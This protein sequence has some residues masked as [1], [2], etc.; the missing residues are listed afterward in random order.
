[1]PAHTL[2]QLTPRVWWLNPLS[3]T[4]RPTLGVVAGQRGS[5]IIDAG[6]SPAHIAALRAELERH[7]LP[8]PRLVALTHW[9]WDHIFGAAALDVPAIAGRETQRVVRALAGLPWDDEALDRRV[10]AGTEIAFCRDMIKAELP[11]RSRLEIRPPEVAFDG[12]L[13]VDLGGAACRLIHVGGDHSPD[14]IVVHLPAERVVF[15]GDATYDDLYHGPRRLTAGQLFP[16]LDRLIALD[17]D[18]YVG[19]HD[20]EPLTRA[21]FEAEAAEL[22]AIWG[23]VERVGDDREAL[24][25]ALPGAVGGP[26]NDGHVMIADAFLAGLRLPTVASPI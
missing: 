18:H 1:M 21:A 17:V 11:D 23:A 10:A 4:D 25:A 7:G 16:L 5:L 12:E 6:N 9:H 15:L 24:L 13:D 20:P 26:P 19:G 22:R 3:D 8:A 2:R 14:G